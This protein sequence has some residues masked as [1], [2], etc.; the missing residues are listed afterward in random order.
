VFEGTMHQG[1]VRQQ[2]ME[3]DLRRALMRN[4][5]L[6]LVYQ[7]IVS[8]E[9]RRIKGFEVLV[10]WTNGPAGP[11]SPAE[12]IPMAEETGLIVALG[13]TVLREACRQLATWRSA[14]P[15]WSDLYVSVNV[16]PRQL[17][18][19]TFSGMMQTAIDHSGIDPRAL[20]LEITESAVMED[21]EQAATLLGQLRQLGVLLALDDFG[22][23]YSSLSYLSGLP[24]DILKVDQSFVRAMRTS[25][26]NLHIVRMIGE[27]GQAL[28][29]KI[30]AE[31]LESEKDVQLVKSL[32]YELGQGYYFGAPLSVADATRLLEEA[33]GQEQAARPT[34]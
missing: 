6:R 20:C 3:S 24:L 9:N 23:G 17:A 25:D 4:E 14:L 22:T 30:V 1:L 13:R 28:K 29:L 16:S 15:E 8:L 32:N 10:R 2:Q 12:F 21:Q 26:E 11:I 31:G 34:C 33:A 5:E 27:L 7:P 18:D 19:S